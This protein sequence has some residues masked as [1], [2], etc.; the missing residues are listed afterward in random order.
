[1]KNKIQQLSNNR[2]RIKTVSDLLKHPSRDFQVDILKKTKEFDPNFKINSIYRQRFHDWYQQFNAEYGGDLSKLNFINDEI[3]KLS[4][5]YVLDLE[6]TDWK[7]NTV[8]EQII[9]LASEEVEKY[10]KKDH[11][12]LNELIRYLDNEQ[13]EIFKYLERLKNAQ[14]AKSSEE[15]IIQLVEDVSSDAATGREALRMLHH[16]GVMDFLKSNWKGSSK[17]WSEV[18][19]RILDKNEATLKRSIQG[20][21]GEGHGGGESDFRTLHPSEKSLKLLNQLERL[22]TKSG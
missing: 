22:S 4:V 20:H 9:D 12:L 3:D 7:F 5:L 15:N 2:R 21:F 1:M 8:P 18:L 17:S 14:T 16:L 13:R 10:P 19:G 6:I 11:L